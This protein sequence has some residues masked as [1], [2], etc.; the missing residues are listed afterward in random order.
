MSPFFT[1]K[2][3]QNW[4]YKNV[5]R[6]FHVLNNIHVSF[7]LWGVKKSFSSTSFKPILFYTF[8]VGAY[9]HTCLCL[10]R[11][12]PRHVPGMYPAWL[13]MW[14]LATTACVG[15]TLLTKQLSSL[16][17]CFLG[18]YCLELEIQ[19]VLFT[20]PAPLYPELLQGVFPVAKSKDFHFFLFRQ[21]SLWSGLPQQTAFVELIALGLLFN[22][23]GAEAL[24]LAHYGGILLQSSFRSLSPPSNDPGSH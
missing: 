20:L 17:S 15:S 2:N 9:M 24:F 8:F 18:F 19:K 16:S 12:L 13:F 23:P 3:M 1:W 4:H 7:M 22:T 6:L 5:F 10:G 14:V 11:F 21:L